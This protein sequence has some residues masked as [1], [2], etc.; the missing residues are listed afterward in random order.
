LVVLT[1][2]ACLAIDWLL[3]RRGSPARSARVLDGLV[4][5]NCTRAEGLFYGPGHT[6][7]RLEP[8]GS[9]RIGIDDFA[10]RVVGRVDRIETVTEGVE[11][12]RR[13]AAF[14][15]HQ[16]DKSVGFAAPLEGEVM[17]VNRTALDDPAQ[18][19]SDPYGD[20]WL[21]QVRSKNLAAALRS[22]RVGEEAGRWLHE[23]TERLR[24]FL[25]AQPAADAVGATLQDGGEPRAA[26]LERLDARAWE[27]FEHEFLVA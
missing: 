18:V 22:L 5:L 12:G 6:W 4:P 24:R 10:R 11:L 17:A 14:V 8:D 3:Q 25:N 21:M 26:L 23:E 19:A 9:A 20:G 2:L 27:R 1:L 13:D 16:G 7:A 15:L